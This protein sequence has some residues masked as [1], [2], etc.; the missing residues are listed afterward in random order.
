MTYSIKNDKLQGPGVDHV[1]T[2]KKSSGK[3]KPKF[4]VIHYTAGDNY[5]ADVRTLSSSPAQVSCHLVIGPNGE[6]TQV[7]DFTDKLWHAGKSS[8]EGYNYL[9][10]YSIGIEV[11][12][13]GWATATNDPNV[14]RLWNGR[15]VKNGDPW[16]YEYAAHKIS[17][18]KKWW[19]LF[20]EKQI[21]A[22]KEI[23]SVL[24]NHYDL[25]EAVGHD[26]IAPSRKIDPG[27]CC[28]DSVFHFLN[29]NK[30]PNPVVKE[31]H[32]DVIGIPTKK[33]EVVKV[34][35]GGLNFRTGGGTGSP[36]KGVLPEGTVVTLM[37]V[38]GLW[39][40]VETPAGYVGWVHSAYLQK[41]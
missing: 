17:G 36:V 8:W 6:V 26:Q 4:L 22:L 1:S 16:H 5:K 39:Y 40:K 9:N 11:T 10:A 7:G 18:E 24:M 13:P 21:E 34:G 32:H 23:G 2:T 38:R 28:P 14:F 12:C 33:Y 41:V 19:A 37:E 15:S 29:G 20:T 3:L 25:D 27:P 35:D 30:D 31:E